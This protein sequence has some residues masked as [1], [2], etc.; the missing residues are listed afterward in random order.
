M[1]A[2]QPTDT[3]EFTKR[4]REMSSQLF[5]T[6]YTFK[7]YDTKQYLIVIYLILTNECQPT[8][9]YSGI[10]EKGS[11]DVVSAV[12]IYF[13]DIRHKTILNCYLI[14]LDKKMPTN[15]QRGTES[16]FIIQGLNL[17]IFQQIWL[18]F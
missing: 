2:N 14:N 10:H 1:N 11:G 7:I 6:L 12:T 17:D 15:P 9:R 16:S 8:N 4:V 3:E 13:Q 5:V 18:L